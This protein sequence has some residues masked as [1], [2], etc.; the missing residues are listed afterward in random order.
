MVK[1]F[2][3]TLRGFTLVELLVTIGIMGILASILLVSLNSAR[4]SAR[5]AQARSQVN[6]IR[7]AI[8]LLESQTNEWPGHKTIDDVQSGASG[9]EI[10]DLNAS[11]AGLV[12]SDGGY[13][14]WDG[15]YINRVPLDPWGHP[16]FFDTDYDIGSG[17]SRWAAVIGSFGPN[18]AGQNV[19]DSDNII[20]VLFAE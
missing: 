3:K 5:L 18:G 6:Q 2:R 13:T 11:S 12:A 1:I 8:S 14:N 4:A 7:K 10:W 20:E 16:Y 19:Y 9:N 17:T 15:P